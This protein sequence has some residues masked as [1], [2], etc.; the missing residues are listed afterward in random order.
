MNRATPGKPP[1]QTDRARQIPKWAGRYAQNRTLPTIAFF[2]V[3]ILSIAVLGV[4]AYLAGRAYE[5]GDTRGEVL[6][7]AAAAVTFAWILWFRFVVGRQITRRIGDALYGEEGIALTEPMEQAQEAPPHLSAAHFLLFAC[8]VTWVALVLLEAIPHRYLL[9]AFALFMAPFT[10]YFY[11]VR[12]RGVVSPFMLLWPLLYTIHALLL[13]L[14]APVYISGGPD[15]VYETLNLLLPILGYGLLAALIGH[16]YSRLALR[17]LR[18]LAAPP[19]GDGS[20]EV[21]EQ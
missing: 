19:E 18:A 3:L 9:A 15:G 21:I 10:V 2:V 11:A 16:V 17:R 8:A 13:A 7:A 20:A 4:L 14:G 1:D 5:A 6:F 12:Y